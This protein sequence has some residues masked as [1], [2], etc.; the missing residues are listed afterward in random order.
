VYYAAWA[1]GAHEP[2]A[3]L[4]AWVAKAR[5][6]R[7][8]SS[9]ADTALFLHGAVGYTWEHDLQLLFK[10]GKSDS[11]LLGGPGVY[12]DRIADALELVPDDRAAAV[13]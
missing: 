11:Q 1:V 12:D 2:N 10:R 6:A 13:R 8:A 3:E 4:D 9:V 7:A 5:A